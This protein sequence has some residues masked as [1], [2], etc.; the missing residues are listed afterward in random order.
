MQPAD[1]ALRVDA[2]CRVLGRHGPVAD[3]FAVGD[4]TA[5][6]PYT[7]TATYQAEIVVAELRGSGRDAD[8]RAVPRV[9]YTDPP[10]FCVGLTEEQA[11]GPLVTASYDVEGTARAFIE[12]PQ[13]PG[14]VQLLAT[15]DGT[16]VGAAAVAPHAESWIGELALAVRAGLTADLLADHVHPHPSW[17]EALH[18][19]ARELVDRLADVS[20]AT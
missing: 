11:D 6:A 13:L 19:A 5:V 4:V 15:P 20:A 7:H 17:S 1:G 12:R 18:P 14:R 9:V 2:R 16:L 8:Y 3:V 10:V